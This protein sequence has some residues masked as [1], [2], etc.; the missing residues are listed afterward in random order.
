MKIYILTSDR[1]IHILEGLQHCV[2]KYWNPNPSVV[3]LGYKEPSFNLGDNFEFIS[4][5]KDRGVGHIGND[6]INFFNSI[7][8]EHFIF[9]VDDFFPIREVDTDLLGYLEKKMV[10]EDIS[11]IPLIDQVSNKPNSIIE[12]KDNFTIIEM[13]QEADYRK[14]AVWSM[15]SK[16]YFLKYMWDTMNLWEWEL[17]VKCK[18]D[19]HRIVGTNGKY[20]LQ[21]CHLYEKGNLKLDW[22]KDSEGLDT[23]LAEDRVVIMNMIHI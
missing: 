7:E 2:N 11:R 18:N 17:D 23:M 4:L 1:N 12:K 8:D 14:S 16:S 21:S 15:W 13:S 9:T 20:I 10:K 5:G 3:V 19:G 6:L 22:W